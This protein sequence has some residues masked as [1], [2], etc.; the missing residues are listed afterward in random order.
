MELS[1][2]CQCDSKISVENLRA[3]DFVIAAVLLSI[4]DAH[5]LTKGLRYSDFSG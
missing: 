3:D 2:D 4:E 5:P 1:Q